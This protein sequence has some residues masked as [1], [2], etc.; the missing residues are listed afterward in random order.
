MSGI[1]E[2]QTPRR[3]AQ[4]V[5]QSL[6]AGSK[7]TSWILLMAFFFMALLTTF[8][9]AEDDTAAQ[10]A[11]SCEGYGPQTPRDIDDLA[12]T[13]KRVFSTAPDYAQMNL[14]SLSQ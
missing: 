3:S 14:C 1:G 9:F 10:Q 6:P 7:T 11:P 5:A 2:K 8:A 4:A 13:N 12:G